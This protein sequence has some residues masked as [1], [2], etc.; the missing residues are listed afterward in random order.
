MKV[1]MDSLVMNRIVH[2]HKFFLIRCVV[3]I[4]NGVVNWLSI[5]KKKK[6]FSSILFG[7]FFACPSEKFPAER[8]KIFSL[9]LSLSKNK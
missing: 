6:L 3:P 5:K 1:I 9:S 4:R 7:V 2:L 8:E